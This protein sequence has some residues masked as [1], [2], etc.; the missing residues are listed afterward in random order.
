ML[1]VTLL[2]W[3]LNSGATQTAPSDWA[4]TDIRINSVSQYTI[5][6][7]II[8][9][10]ID[11]GA[12]VK[13]PKLSGSLW[14]NLK[15]IPDNQIDDDNNDFI[16]DVHG[17]DF[18]KSSGRLSDKHGH[19][20]HITG[21]INHGAPKARLMILKYYDSNL[22]PTETIDN[23]VKAIRYATKM[24][25]DII[26][27]SAGG[28]SYSQE[29]YEA[30]KDAGAKGILVVAAAGNEG[31]DSSLVPY[32]PANYPLTNILSVTAHNPARMILD[33]SNYGTGTVDI[34]APGENIL[35]SLPKG[36]FGVMT[37]TSQATAFVTAVAA[38]TKA[39]Y[40]SLR[41]PEEI[42]THILATSIQES[43]QRNKTK[44]DLRLDALQSV[45]I[46]PEDKNPL[47]IEHRKINR[48]LSSPQKPLAL[49]KR[50]TKALSSAGA[51]GNRE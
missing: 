48:G 22:A 37:G 2:V 25:A 40:P 38:I 26:N 17:W 5:S 41:K 15:E 29:E 8:I 7:D 13:H 31:A 20:T 12:D 49:A 3:S 28:G 1:L 36:G 33:S 50:I 23:T 34:S 51:L 47:K 44:Q 43:R 42:K 39:R 10:V 4:E 18:V 32:Y 30:L 35:S 21:I 24:G 11:T 46:A 19:G 16:D 9:A 45:M 14:K 27:Y 6:R